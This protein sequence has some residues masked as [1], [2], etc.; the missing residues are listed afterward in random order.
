MSDTHEAKK[1]ALRQHLE[2]ARA[3]LLEV[4]AK[5][6]PEEWEKPVQSEGERWTALQMMRHLQD[7]HVGLVGQ[8]G[9][10]LQGEAT[11]PPDFDIDRWNA[12]V[13]RKTAEAAL[14][15]EQA[16]ETLK[17]SHTKLLALIDTLS[18]DDWERRGFQPGLGREVS[19]EEFIH[20]IGLHERTHAQEMEAVHV[21]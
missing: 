10:L 11:V 6:T 14:T 13:Q 8:M 21:D 17:A 5:L 18:E 16:Q 20:V 9:R 15:V 3:Y 19:L 7:A 2:E 1:T 12:R 4:V